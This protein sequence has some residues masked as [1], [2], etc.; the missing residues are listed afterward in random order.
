MLHYGDEGEDNVIDGQGLWR[1]K[2]A[3]R[4]GVHRGALWLTTSGIFPP[5]QERK[6]QVDGRVP[7]SHP[8]YQILLNTFER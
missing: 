1:E 2:N 7:V 8:R 5:I 4:D 3:E 6:E